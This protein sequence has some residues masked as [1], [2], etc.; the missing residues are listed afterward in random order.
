MCFIIFAALCIAM[1]IW[2]YKQYQH[3]GDC[4]DCVGQIVVSIISGIIA[5]IFL[6]IILC[7]WTTVA[8]EHVIDNKIAM[9]QEENER[10]ETEID[11]IVQQYM[12]Y[13]K[14]TFEN[15][16]IDP[17][18]DT[19][20]LVSLF[21]ELKADTLVQQQIELHTANAR[22]IK[23]LKEEKIN[24]STQKWLLYFGR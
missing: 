8:N 11:L 10:I 20:V 22:Q 3:Y 18:T 24:L 16:A 17:G 6:I 4:Y 7:S 12:A 2:A 5:A 15:I 13:E 23:S 1:G 21:P 9:Y 19:M 14:E